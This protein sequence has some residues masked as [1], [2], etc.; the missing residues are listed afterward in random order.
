MKREKQRVRAQLEGVYY[1]ATKE[2]YEETRATGLMKMRSTG[3]EWDLR[4]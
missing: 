3:D 2:M 1:I 4:P